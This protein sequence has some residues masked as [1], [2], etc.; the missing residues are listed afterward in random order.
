MM[1]VFRYVLLFFLAIVILIRFETWL[2]TFLPA[3]ISDIFSIFLVVAAISIFWGRK[4][5][6]QRWF[7]DLSHRINKTRGPLFR[8]LRVATTVIGH[9]VILAYLAPWYLPVLFGS[10]TSGNYTGKAQ[11]GQGEDEKRWTCVYEHQK[12]FLKVILRGAHRIHQK[13]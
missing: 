8:K 4:N 3:E 1:R 13:I 10:T 2:D 9:I 11:V 5:K 7:G 12:A 6:F